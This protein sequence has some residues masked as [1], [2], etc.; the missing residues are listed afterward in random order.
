MNCR[1]QTQCGNRDRG[2]RRQYTH[3]IYI[4]PAV[5]IHVTSNRRLTRAQRAGAALNKYE[6]AE[7]AGAL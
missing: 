5:Y 1:A 3:N 7:H 4:V 2:V 6:R